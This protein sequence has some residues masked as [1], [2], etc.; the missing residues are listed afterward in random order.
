MRAAARCFLLPPPG[1]VCKCKGRVDSA[2]L[3]ERLEDPREA[4]PGE[5]RGSKELCA[6]RGAARIDAWGSSSSSSSSS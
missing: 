6:F 5:E 2:D 3:E 4:V 1:W